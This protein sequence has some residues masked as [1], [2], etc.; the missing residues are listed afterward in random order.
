[1][2][3]ALVAGKSKARPG[4]GGKIPGADTAGHLFQVGGR[5]P[6]AISGSDGRTYAG[7]RHERD[8]NVFFFEYFE[9]ANMSNS[10]R[11]PA[12]QGDADARCPTLSF[13]IGRIARQLA[14]EGLYRPD[15]FPETSHGSSHPPGSARYSTTELAT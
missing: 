1:P 6:T 4:P 10:A 15:Y 8:G 3:R 2:D 9:H 11:E 12:T 5:L 7:P 14:P 13:W